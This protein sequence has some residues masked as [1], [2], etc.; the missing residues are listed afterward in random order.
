MLKYQLFFSFA[1]GLSI[2][3][4]VTYFVMKPKS[5]VITNTSEVSEH[6]VSNVNQ[7][8]PIEITL[9]DSRLIDEEK[10]QP[11]ATSKSSVYPPKLI[12]KSIRDFAETDRAPHTYENETQYLTSILQSYSGNEQK[13]NAIER[14]QSEYDANAISSALGDENSSI[15]MHAINALAY[16]GDSESVRYIGQ[17]IIS[18]QDVNVRLEALELLSTLTHDANATL[19][20][21]YAALNDKHDEVKEVAARLLK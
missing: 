8:Q 10:L 19:F 11:V 12:L 6:N 20:I 21:E 17:A 14:L 2:G 16:I 3:G 9:N 1:L 5:I 18:D 7:A 15:R 4:A 13:L